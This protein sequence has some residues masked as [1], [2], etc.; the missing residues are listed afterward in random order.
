MTDA[1]QAPRFTVVPRD[2]VAPNPDQPAA[3]PV[4]KPAKKSTETDDAQ[5]QRSPARQG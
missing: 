4:K 2:A 1:D 5:D 3:A